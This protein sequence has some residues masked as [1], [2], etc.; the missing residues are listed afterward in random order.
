MPSSRESPTA[1]WSF[2]VSARIK[3]MQR[4]PN[5]S[6]LELDLGAASPKYIKLN[7][8]MATGFPY[9]FE[10]QTYPRCY[11]DF[12]PDG[13]ALQGFWEAAAG[14]AFAIAGFAAAC[15]VSAIVRALSPP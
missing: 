11:V 2:I 7:R 9:L 8:R 3:H 12:E 1:N 6:L 5:G 4:L 15:I 14:A 13:P 10:G